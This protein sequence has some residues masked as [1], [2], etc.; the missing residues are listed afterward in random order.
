MRE[1]KV[2]V[3]N[4]A[5]Y[6]NGDSKGRW[7]TLPTPTEEIFEK[8][9]DTNELDENGQPHG[10]FAIHDYEAPFEINEFSNIENLNEAAEMME[11][12]SEEDISIICAMKD[13]GYIEHFLEGESKLGDIVRFYDCKDMSDVAEEIVNERYGDN[14]EYEFFLRNFNYQSYGEEL[15]SSGTYIVMD[16]DLIVEYLV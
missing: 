7:F 11:G 6:N 5:A 14:E 2:F 8:I 15:D 3:E 1:I 12:L 4:L 16:N 9:F 13:E 10:D